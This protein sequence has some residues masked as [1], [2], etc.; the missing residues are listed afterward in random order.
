MKIL[1]QK[2][3]DPQFD[4]EN[5]SFAILEHPV[6][7]FENGKSSDHAVSTANRAYINGGNSIAIFDCRS[8]PKIWT[9]QSFLNK[10]IEN[11]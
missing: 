9:V 4:V 7:F 6:F 8:V 5:V 3:L 1:A 2:S 10:D 11:V